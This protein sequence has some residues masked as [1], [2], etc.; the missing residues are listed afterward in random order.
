MSERKW[1]PEQRQSME[2]RGGSL[3]ISAAAGS[4][5][6]A[7][8]VERII[9]LI[10]DPDHR[11]DVDRLL[12]VTFTRAAAAEMRQR[13]SNALAKKMA[14]K[15]DDLYY[16]RQQ[17]LLPRAYISTVHG[18]CT[19]L[20]QEYAGQTG[21]PVGFRVADESQSGLLAA[22]ALDE[23]LEENYRRADPAFM[24]LAAQLNS[25]RND[26]ALRTAVE[27]AYAFMQ[28]Q[29]FPDRWLQKQIDAYSAVV[30]LEQTAWMQTILQA[31]DMELEYAASLCYRAY[32]VSAAAVL[33]PYV[34]TLL[35]ESQQLTRLRESLPTATYDEMQRKVCA[36]T[37]GRLAPVRA[38]DEALTEAKEEV[39]ALRDAAKKS[40]ARCAAL[41]CGT[42]AECRAD[43][44]QMAPLVDALGALV[45]QF[46]DRYVTLK[47]QEKLL[48]YNDLEH[49]SL[50][51]LLDAEGHPTPLA[52][53]L[54]RRF[55]HVMVDE[56][57]DTNAAQEALFR[58]I[59]RKEENLFFVG[60]VKQS[61]DGFRQAMPFLFTRRRGEYHSYCEENPAYPATIT[62]KNNFRSRRT[63]TDTVNFLFRQLMS[64][65]LG[66]V[67]YGDGQRLV[68]GAAEGYAGRTEDHALQA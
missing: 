18:F 10:T 16:Q 49:E 12:V 13:L 23:V 5:K 60:D 19:R 39:K 51:L 65:R 48:D 33:E 11:V 41:F 67:V 55:A 43:L 31:L 17:M 8:L 3:L 50:R 56:Y 61:I 22:Q 27:S 34:D 21:L 9:R 58:A 30:P 6:T 68:C 2:A 14:E 42:E 40:L 20:L 46:T 66:G 25:G 62:L 47:R 44:A 63:V 4:G 24:A 45:R 1:T 54:S 15:P 35:C 38:K 36:F 59:S 57:Q 29:P 64:E 52:E 7:V 26:M 32:E 37:F 28:A 53:E